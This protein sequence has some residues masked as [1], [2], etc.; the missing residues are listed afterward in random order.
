M[1]NLRMLNDISDLK[2][3]TFGRPY[4]RHGLKLL[5][6]LANEFLFFN[7]NK[8]IFCQYNPC[9]AFY[10]FHQFKN[11]ND[12]NGVKLLPDANIPYYMLGNLKSDGSD[13]LPDYVRKDHNSFICSSNMDRIIVSVDDQNIENVYVTEHRDRTDFNK[14]ATF[15]ISKELLMIIREMP[16]EEFLFQSGYSRSGTKADHDRKAW[17]LSPANE[18][19]GPKNWFSDLAK[20][21]QEQRK[22]SSSLPEEEQGQRNWFLSQPEEDRGQKS[23]F[24]DPVEK[25]QDERKWSSSLQEQDQGQRNWFVSQPE[26]DR[27][28]K[29][30]F[31]D[32]VEEEKGQRKWSL[33]LPKGEQ[34]QRNWFSDQPEED[35][36]NLD[37]YSR[38]PYHCE[39]NMDRII[40]SVDDE[41]IDR[42]YVTEHKRWHAGFNKDATYRISRGLIEAIRKLSLKDFLLQTGYSI[43]PEESDLKTGLL[44]GLTMKTLGDLEQLK[45]SRFGQPHPRHGLRLLYWFTTKCLEFNQNNNMMQSCCDPD[46]GKFGFHKFENKHEKYFGKLLPIVALP[47]YEVGNLSKAASYSLPKYLRKDYTGLID[48]SNMDRIIVSFNKNTNSFDK[49]YVTQHRD[50]SNFN[51]NSTYDISSCLVMMIR[52]LPLEKFLSKTGY[53]FSLSPE[54][55]SN[56]HPSCPA[57]QTTSSMDSNLYLTDIL[58]PNSTRNDS[59]GTMST[60]DQNLLE[61]SHTSEQHKALAIPSICSPTTTFSTDQD[62]HLVVK[63]R[64]IISKNYTQGHHEVSPTPFMHS[65]ANIHSTSQD[66]Q[67]EVE[68]FPI[69]MKSHTQGHHKALPTLSTSI[70]VTMSSTE[71]NIHLKVESSPIMKKSDNQRHRGAPSTSFINNRAN[72]HNT[73]QDF[74]Q[75]IHLKIKHSP[76]MTQEQHEAPPTVSIFI[77][78]PSTTHFMCSPADFPQS[79]HRPTINSQEELDETGFGQPSPRNGLA[80]LLWVL[81]LIH[82]FKSDPNKFCY[83]LKKFGAHEFFNREELLPKGYLYYTFGNLGKSGAEMLPENIRKH[84]TGRCD[85]SNM[86]RII[87]GID[88]NEDSIYITEHYKKESTYRIGTNFISEFLRKHQP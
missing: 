7:N 53:F 16:F 79:T 17:I 82:Q 83:E 69:T 84:Y 34:G 36:V 66:V 57:E 68:S 74:H 54:E 1:T 2:N 63:S 5:Y 43:Q 31:S 60:T 32:L 11:R 37:V 35:R 51:K 4:P 19:R 72:I 33:S 70:P 85:Q 49:V 30:W 48:D 29:N 41:C 26:E 61:R 3:S 9:N 65:P 25:E 39:R 75:T 59:P 45:E 13:E 24:S 64:S 71:Q 38:N 28:P 8:K 15:L 10:G 20:E 78:T 47:Y 56:C 6:W 67:P 46:T 27:G 55:L 73:K 62:I 52:E 42:V 14:K 40:V 76:I 80:L 86:G 12:K 21:K 44:S 18:D 22:W 88:D 77:P 87:I 81:N 58:P 50:Q 23:W